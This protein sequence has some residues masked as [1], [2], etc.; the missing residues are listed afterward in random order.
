MTQTATFGFLS[1]P[2]DRTRLEWERGRLRPFFAVVFRQTERPGHRTK[3]AYT[4]AH[5]PRRS[6]RELTTRAV[7]RRR[8]R[9][10]VGDDE[11]RS[12]IEMFRPAS[13]EL[14]EPTVYNGILGVASWQ[15]HPLIT[16]EIG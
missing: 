2:L 6:S 5:A 12:A 13:Y 9:R 7:R 10:S 3:C 8:T 4:G 15:E 1:K 14:D 16:T 11:T